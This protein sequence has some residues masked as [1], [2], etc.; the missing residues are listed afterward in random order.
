MSYTYL[1]HAIRHVSKVSHSDGGLVEA[2]DDV[3]DRQGDLVGDKVP[4]GGV[5]DVL[6]EDIGSG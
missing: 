5:E 4:P 1:E 6:V 2:R 3:D